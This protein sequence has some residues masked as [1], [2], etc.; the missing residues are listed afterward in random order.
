MVQG[1]SKLLQ[2]ADR[3][4]TSFCLLRLEET[5]WIFSSLVRL[6]VEHRRSHRY[7]NVL[8][9]HIWILPN[10]KDFLIRPK[11]LC[12]FQDDGVREFGAADEIVLP[13]DRDGTWKVIVQ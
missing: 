7:A 11:G 2:A 13:E 5:S 4:I 12:I 10:G 3:M 1:S 9:S 6:R 8:S